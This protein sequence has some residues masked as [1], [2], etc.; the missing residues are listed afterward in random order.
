MIVMEWKDI[1]PL[2]QELFD[3]IRT[4]YLIETEFKVA[5]A[6]AIRSNKLMRE[7]TL[8]LDELKCLKRLL[9]GVDESNE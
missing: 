8:Q 2:V 3:A 1:D 9:E 6:N 4:T 7:I 5:E